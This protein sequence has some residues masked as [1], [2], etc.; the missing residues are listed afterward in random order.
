MARHLPDEPSGVDWLWL[1]PRYL[2]K[3]PWAWLAII[4]VAIP[5]CFF[6]DQF[7]SAPQQWILGIMGWFTLLMALTTRTARERILVLTLVLLATAAEFTF[8][9]VAGW[10][11]YRLENVPPWIP[12]AH[13]LIF[14]SALLWVEM[15]T[16]YAHATRFRIAVTL[17]VVA[18][19][20]F[21]LIVGRPDAVGA[22]GGALLLIWL[23]F[24]GEDRG[25]FYVL[26]WFIVCYLEICGVAI[27]AWSW[28][29]NMPGIGWSQGN[30]PSGIV[31]VY[32]AIDLLA[33]GTTALVGNVWARTGGA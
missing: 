9:E 7:L 30:P 5:S 3:R 24:T 25:R 15:P 27:G 26:M 21:G 8:S 32:G 14:L 23:W 1:W 17:A 16:A 12:P 10:Y 29:E 19:S 2:A 13:G 6:V 11:T 28:A 33:F 31:G 4:L 18:Y 20:M 22:A